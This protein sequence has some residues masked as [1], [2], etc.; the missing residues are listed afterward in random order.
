[1]EPTPTS[2]FIQGPYLTYYGKGGL[3][4][5]EHVEPSNLVRGHV[6]PCG[7]GFYQSLQCLSP[8]TFPTLVPHHQVDQENPQVERADDHLSDQGRV[9]E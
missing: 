7:N 9:L 2:I 8:L 3:F 1:M 4:H 5:L 6:P